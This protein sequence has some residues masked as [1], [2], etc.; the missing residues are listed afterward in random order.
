MHYYYQCKSALSYHQNS[1]LIQ[2]Q[3]LFEKMSDSTNDATVG[4][5][6]EYVLRTP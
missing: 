2:M 6:V 5:D 4:A 3:Q 1:Q